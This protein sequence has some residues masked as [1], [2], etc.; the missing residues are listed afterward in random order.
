MLNGI[1]LFCGFATTTWDIAGSLLLLL[2]I[3]PQGAFSGG[4]P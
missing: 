3:V 4:G 1:S 2:K